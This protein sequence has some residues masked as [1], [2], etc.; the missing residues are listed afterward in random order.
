MPWYYCYAD[1]GPCHQSSSEH[2]AWEDEKLTPSEKKDLFN[3]VF[4][5]YDWPIG[6]VKFV[7]KLTKE[8]KIIFFPNTDQS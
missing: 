4:E 1:H 2:L 5:H 8:E 3:S 6:N 7:S